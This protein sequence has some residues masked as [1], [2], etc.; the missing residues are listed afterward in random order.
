MKLYEFVRGIDT[1][2]YRKTRKKRV[3]EITETGSYCPKEKP[4]MAWSHIK[5]I[6]EEVNDTE[7]QD[8][9]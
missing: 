8:V 6:R 9:A 4:G 3:K 5:E 7:G 2:K 1:T